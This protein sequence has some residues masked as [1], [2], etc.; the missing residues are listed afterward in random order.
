VSAH[1]S[2]QARIGVVRSIQTGRAAP[3]GPN[4]VPSAFVKEPVAGEVFVDTLGIAG[5]EQADLRV[6]GGR[7]KAVYGYA[8]SNY[9]TWRVD[10]PHYASLLV[11][12]AF[13]ENLT[14]DECDEHRVCVGDTVRV[15][16]AIL[17]IT[18]PRQPCYKFALRFGDIAMPRAMIRNGLCG[19][20]YRVLTPGHIRAGQELVLATRPYPDWPIW[21]VNRS[22]TQRGGSPAER[23]EF[24]AIAASLD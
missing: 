2:E 19:W 18:Q 13:G 22:I 9:S 24:A 16:D 7:D 3:L 20:Y 23:Q 5:D 4:G 12:G 1:S 21:R 17:Q 14:L 15:G 8:F 6:H 11:P 10:F